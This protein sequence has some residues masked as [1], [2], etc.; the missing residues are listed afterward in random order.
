MVRS[1]RIARLLRGASISV[2]VGLVVMCVLWALQ[3]HLIYFPSVS[4]APSAAT[5]RPGAVDV[6]LRTSDGLRLGAWLVPA[7]RPDRGVSV[8]VAN[9]NG[10]D[11]SLRLPLADALSAH[12]LSVL[13]FD[14]RGYGGNSG[15]PSEA[16]LA[17]DVRAA[18]RFLAGHTDGRIV[19]YGE[20]L[21][22]A[23]V[24]ELATEH[25]P[26]GLVLRSPFTDLTSVG[27]WHYPYLPVKTLLRDRYPL[28]DHL[29]QVRVPTVV[30]YGTAD[31]IVPPG[32]S[33][34]VA[35]AA[36]GLTRTV[37]IQAADHNDT[38]LLYGP[39]LIDAVVDLADQIRR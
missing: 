35:E 14:Y 24:T 13:L 19:F 37:A 36:P 5:I 8:L 12:G 1:R 29:T 17:R 27:R 25:P 11:R 39:E 18:Y 26:A 21:G 9:G 7:E 31:S 38:A 22:A 33:R 10:G 30:V 3:R 2:V 16:G 32:F 34:T 4:R 28:I 20:S 23:V 6:T 15:S